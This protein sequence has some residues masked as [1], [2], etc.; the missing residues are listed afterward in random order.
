MLPATA[1]ASSRAGGVHRPLRLVSIG[2]MGS[3]TKGFD[4]MCDVIAILR[5]R[6][7]E[8]VLTIVGGGGRLDDIRRT[9][10]Q[11]GV[12]GA[13]HLTG[14]LSDPVRVRAELDAA[15]LYVTTSRAEGLSRAVIEAL[16]RGL[17][18]VSTRAGGVEELLPDDLLAPI[19]DA[20]SVASIVERL[21]SDP[22]R[23]ASS[24]REGILMSRAVAELARPELLT[25][26][27]KSVG[28]RAE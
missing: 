20:E 1:F 26:F 15:D 27:V 22:A 3:A 8:A 25:E 13:V 9:A 21:S 24:S 28:T 18:V 19:D 4:V 16:A 11:A 6:G 14:H 12:A 23:L 17:P 10:E 5:S 2:S 7:I